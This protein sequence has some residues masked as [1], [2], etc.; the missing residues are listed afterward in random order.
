MSTSV[1]IRASALTV[2]EATPFAASS[3]A[4]CR[5]GYAGARLDRE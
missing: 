3:T 5:A 2:R 4:W 1:L